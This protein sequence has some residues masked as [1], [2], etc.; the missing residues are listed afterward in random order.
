[1][2]SKRQSLTTL[3]WTTTVFFL[4]AIWLYCHDESTLSGPWILDDKGTITMNPVIVQDSPW[5]E[6]WIRDFWGR[7]KPQ[8]SKSH[9]S[10]RPLTTASYKLNYIWIQKYKNSSSK[11]PAAAATTT[12]VGDDDT[13]WFHVVDRILHGIVSALSYIVAQHS[14]RCMSLSSS[15]LVFTK[16]S[17]GCESKPPR[18]IFIHSV[19]LQ[20]F[21]TAL[22]FTA[23]PIHVEAVSN[24]T[25]RAE[26]CIV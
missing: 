5:S 21:I 9:K 10:W 13:Y 8:D 16:S 7:N 1:M 3:L 25:G 19:S 6:V 15:S 23:H 20:A 14:L 26:V 24:T 17:S 22:L 4:L 12:T 18:C 2:S 11:T